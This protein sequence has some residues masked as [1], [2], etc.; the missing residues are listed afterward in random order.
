MQFAAG[1]LGKAGFAGSFDLRQALKAA[2]AFVPAAWRQGWLAL[3]VLFALVVA[4]QTVLAGSVGGQRIVIIAVLLFQFVVTGALYRIALFGPEARREGLGI[5][6]VQF[7][8]PEWRLIGAGLLVSL[9]WLMVFV[10]LCVVLA[11]FLSAAGLA[12]RVGSLEAMRHEFVSGPQPQGAILL[13]TVVVI[14]FILI[15]LSIR[16]WL[17][18]A[19]TVARRQVV[20]LQALSLSAGQTLKLLLGYVILTLP[21]VVIGAVVPVQWGMISVWLNLALGIGLFWPLTVGFFASAY[22]QIMALR[23]AA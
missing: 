4:G 19:A 17:H 8:R 7:A 9:F 20:S 6:G 21:F 12:E 11:L 22:R 18:Q 13:L 14:M 5:G 2:V 23:A 1:L 16:L 10:M 15:T 3:G